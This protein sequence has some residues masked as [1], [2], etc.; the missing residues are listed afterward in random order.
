MPTMYQSVANRIITAD[1][2]RIDFDREDLYR[3]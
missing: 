3:R 1:K 2:T